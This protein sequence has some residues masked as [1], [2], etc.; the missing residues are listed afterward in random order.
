MLFR[1]LRVFSEAYSCSI[2][3][4]LLLLLIIFTWL[5]SLK[6]LTEDAEEPGWLLMLGI[7]RRFMFDLA[8]YLGGADSSHVKLD[9]LY[10][11]SGH[12]KRSEDD[13][14]L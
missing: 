8:I 5:L 1:V 7:L 4:F 3:S 2:M 10:L 12:S 6:L 11:N 13:V 9:I 14:I